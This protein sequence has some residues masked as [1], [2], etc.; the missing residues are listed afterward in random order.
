MLL[1]LFTGF[2]PTETEREEA[3]LSTPLPFRSFFY[4]F[5]ITAV[6]PRH[7]AAPV[8]S[9]IIV[10]M[11]ASFSSCTI[12]GTLPPDSGNRSPMH[13]LYFAVTLLQA[14]IS[15]STSELSHKTKCLTQFGIIIKFLRLFPK[16]PHRRPPRGIVINSLGIPRL[17]CC[18]WY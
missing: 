1:F 2:L 13:F 11:P 12:L 6:P 17:H 4:P 8:F 14:V 9:A 18:R 3:C 5:M 15:L 10:S 16:Y 7:P